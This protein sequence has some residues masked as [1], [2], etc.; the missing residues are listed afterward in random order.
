MP[1]FIAMHCQEGSP[2]ALVERAWRQHQGQAQTGGAMIAVVTFT[3]T[4]YWLPDQP[5]LSLSA[6]YH[7]QENLWSVSVSEQT[8]AVVECL[9]NLQGEVDSERFA[10]VLQQ[11]GLPCFRTDRPV[12]LQ[13][14]AIPKPWGQE[15]WYTGIE[16]RGVVTAGDGRRV[17]P[18]PWLLAVLPQ[19]LCRGK[20]QQL[21]LL[22]I[23][24]P[25]PEP[26]FGDLYFELHEEKREVYVVTAVDKQAWPDGVGRIRFGFDREVVAQYQDEQ[27]FKAAYAKAVGAYEAVRREIDGVLDQ[28]RQRD[29]VPLNEPVAADILKA[30]LQEVP[31]D[32]LAQEE[33]LRKAM[34]RFTSTLPLSVGDVVKVPTHTPHSLQHG[35]RTIEFQTPVYER[36]IVSFAQKVVTQSHWDTDQA[37]AVMNIQAPE[38]PAHSVVEQAEGVLVEQIVDFEDFTVRRVKLAPGSVYRCAQEGDYSLV[39]SIC[40]ELLLG[41]SM[42][43]PEQA[44]LVPAAISHS[45]YTNQGQTE[46]IFLLAR[47]K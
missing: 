1:Q 8:D 5:Q 22:K 16:Q 30:W 27:S 26:V 32:L 10:G 38:Q 20:H 7:C 31:T 25:L 19:G 41:D 40:G 21:I 29:D 45:F 9:S 36:L 24:D 46:A 15:I 13:T 33:S 47:P 4:Q 37:L 12:S 28:F 18:L 34:E 35:V 3:F 39:I 11:L 23:L 44:M 2:E 14:V 17:V 42:L 43:D 6:I